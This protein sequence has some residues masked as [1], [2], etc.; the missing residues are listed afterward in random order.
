MYKFKLLYSS[1]AIATCQQAIRMRDY[2]SKYT[3]VTKVMNK[4]KWFFPH[5]FICPRI[6]FCLQ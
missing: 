1:L 2:T 5:A 3:G 6:F 4:R